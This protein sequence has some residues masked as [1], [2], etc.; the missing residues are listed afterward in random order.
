MSRTFKKF[1]VNTFACFGLISAIVQFL[2]AIFGNGF[3]LGPPG[4]VIAIT[5]LVSIIYG[6]VMARSKTKISHYYKS[7]DVTVNV[8]VD[9]IL[10]SKGQLVVGFADTFD[11]DTTDDEV[12]DSQS[13][14]G[15]LLDRRFNGNAKSL[16]A[17]IKSSLSKSKTFE[18]EKR[19]DKAKGNLKRYPIGT[20]AVFDSPSNSGKIYGV[21]YSKLRND[22]VAE[23]SV[24]FL[25]E[26]LGQ[27][28]DSV[29]IHGQRKPVNLPLMG[30][31]LARINALDRESIIRMILLSFMARSR[32]QVVCKELTLH[33]YPPDLKHINM[34][35]LEAFI[36]NI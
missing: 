2:S 29:Y 3:T 18:L 24:H 12:I 16:S 19:S 6:L 36:K 26:S 22:L 11:V 7:I 4:L 25:W 9:D 5:L 10:K 21:A 14:Q 33:I 1:A 27:L 31:E 15:Q 23:S 17:H 30:T 13:L 34:L 32:E 8:I 35:E 20:V 28:W